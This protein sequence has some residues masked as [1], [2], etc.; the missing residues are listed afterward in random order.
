MRKIQIQLKFKLASDNVGNKKTFYHC[1]ISNIWGNW[2]PI[3]Q[4]GWWFSGCGCRLDW[5]SQ[6]LP[7]LSFADKI[8]QVPVIRGR[9]Q[10]GGLP[11]MDENCIRGYKR[12]FNPCKTPMVSSKNYGQCIHRVSIY[13]LQK[14]LKIAETTEKQRKANPI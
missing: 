11:D 1:I 13:Q 2:E 14:V 6:C 9:I 12:D 3:A 4:W 10:G 7:C 5:G 8:S